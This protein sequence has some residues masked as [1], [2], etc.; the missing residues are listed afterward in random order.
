MIKNKKNIISDK[1]L[2][3]MDI[4]FIIFLY[5]RKRFMKNKPLP[6]IYETEKKLILNATE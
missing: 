6:Y 4:K 2:K 1:F 5:I 3:F